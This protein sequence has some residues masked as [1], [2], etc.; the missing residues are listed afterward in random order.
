VA[1]PTSPASTAERQELIQQYVEIDAMSTVLHVL[2]GNRYVPEAIDFP[3]GRSLDGPPWDELLSE[4]QL[5]P[6]VECDA[7]LFMRLWPDEE[8]EEQQA[9]LDA[10]HERSEMLAANLLAALAAKSDY[11]VRRAAWLL[12]GVTARMKAA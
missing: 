5:E 4:K 9:E 12:E 3:Y 10:A 2:V 8:D 11:L 1:A 7:E 6:R